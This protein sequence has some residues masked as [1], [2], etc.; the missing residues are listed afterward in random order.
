MIAKDGNFKEV[1]KPI[2]F[3]PGIILFLVIVNV[4]TQIILNV[5]LN[6]LNYNNGSLRTTVSYIVIEVLI[7]I[8]EAIA[9]AIVLPKIN[10]EL[11]YQIPRAIIYAIL[12]NALSLSAGF[13]LFKY[14][15]GM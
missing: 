12:A 14:V 15:P 7:T 1:F 9:Y 8:V 6:F 11:K 4:A 10:K 2:N 5:Y 13:I 3:L